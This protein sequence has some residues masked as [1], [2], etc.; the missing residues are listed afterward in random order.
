MRN[1][2]LF[3]WKYNFFFLFILLETACFLLITQS[4]GYQASSL[5]NS[6]NALSANLY[7]AV[8]NTK[9]YLSLKEE[10]QK[11]MIENA[12]LRTKLKSAYEVLPLAVNVV[13]DTMYRQ[14]YKFISA[15]VISNSVN[16][17]ENYITLN[18]GANQ[19]I[20]K[21]MG[22]FNTEGIVG[23]VKD[24]SG[25]FS[26]CMSFLHK[27]VAVAAKLKD[28]SV[29]QL[30]W[31]GLDPRYALMTDVQTHA[32]ILI[33]DTVTTSTLSTFFPEGIKVG[34]VEH[35]ERR[36]AEPYFTVKVRL[37]TNFSKLNYVYVVVNMFKHEQDSLELNSQKP[38]KK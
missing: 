5:L 18:M 12:W 31:D 32:Q 21:D 23:V 33:G 30:K 38:P 27:S 3:L 36:A 29:G 26:S 20:I 10:N 11:I 14:K 22:V 13:K 4:K 9:E 35:Y 8:A 7:S 17:R 25:N 2:L 28:G 24:V 6:T 19:G 16:R 37:T 34:V 1:L 15:K